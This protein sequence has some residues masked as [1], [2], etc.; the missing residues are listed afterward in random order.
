VARLVAADI[1][2]VSGNIQVT[3]PLYTQ[4]GPLLV[5]GPSASQFVQALIANLTTQLA[6]LGVTSP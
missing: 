6:A 5:D 2:N 1:A 3:L 4:T